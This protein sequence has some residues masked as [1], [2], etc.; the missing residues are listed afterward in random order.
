MNQVLKTYRLSIILIEGRVKT[1]ITLDLI[2][3][4]DD[5]IELIDEPFNSI[6]TTTIISRVKFRDLIIK[7]LVKKGIIKD[8]MAQYLSRYSRNDSRILACKLTKENSSNNINLRNFL[9]TLGLIEFDKNNEL[10]FINDKCL[11]LIKPLLSPRNFNLKQLGKRILSNEEIGDLAE[12][13]VVKYEIK[14]LNKHFPFP[15]KLVEKISAH[16]VSAGYDIESHLVNN[17]D[18][19]IT[20]KIEVKAVS[21]KDYRFYWSKNEMKAAKSYGNKYYLYLVPCLGD[22]KLDMENLKIVQDPHKHIIENGS[23]SCELESASFHW[24]NN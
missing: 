3:M 11:P 21:L 12:D 23:W 16:K 15:E 24:T 1:L 8:E 14:K 18:D 20:I 17:K 13:A 5:R 22:N 4:V 9:M 10:Y 6:N 19:L 7:R 2:E